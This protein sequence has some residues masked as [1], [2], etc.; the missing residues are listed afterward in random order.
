MGSLLEAAELASKLTTMPLLVRVESPSEWKV[1]WECC[2]CRLGLNKSCCCSCRILG[3]PLSQI[4]SPNDDFT[5]FLCLEVFFTKCL[6]SE[7]RLEF[8]ECGGFES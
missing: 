8:L 3:G 7:L 1:E 4:L 6:E 5:T 2:M